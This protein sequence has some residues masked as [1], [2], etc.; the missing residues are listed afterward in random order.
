[1]YGQPFFVHLWLPTTSN[2]E[3]ALAV[4]HQA[5]YT[6]IAQAIRRLHP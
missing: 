2:P 4:L 6:A 3:Q 1:M 5:F